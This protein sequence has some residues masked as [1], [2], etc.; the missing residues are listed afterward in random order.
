MNR[1][2]QKVFGSQNAYWMRPKPLTAKIQGQKVSPSDMIAIMTLTHHPSPSRLIFQM[3]PCL[4]AEV[5]TIWPLHPIILGI[6]SWI[7]I[8]EPMHRYSCPLPITKL[9]G[10]TWGNVIARWDRGKSLQG[11]VA[12][13]AHCAY[14][15]VWSSRRRTCH[16]EELLVNYTVLILMKEFLKIY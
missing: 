4:E 14:L 10:T 6:R 16:R 15:G 5:W 11:D 13:T 2:P 7:H 3:L 9:I 8:C 1:W 12:I